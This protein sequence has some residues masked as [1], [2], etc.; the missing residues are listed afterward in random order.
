MNEKLFW[1]LNS[2]SSILN[3]EFWEISVLWRSFEREFTTIF[4]IAELN[5]NKASRIFSTWF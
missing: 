3:D 5:K 1:T 2:K 4:E